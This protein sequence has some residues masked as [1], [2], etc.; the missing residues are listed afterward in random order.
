MTW[1]KDPKKVVVVALFCCIL[2]GS[3]FPVLKISYDLLGLKAND[4]DAKILFAG[5]RF[6]I[7]GIALFIVSK[8]G[9]KLDMKLNKQEAKKLVLLGFV[10]TSLLYYFF[11]NALANTTGMKAAIL[12]SISTFLVVIISHFIYKDDRLNKQK[13]IGLSL[14]FLGIIL[15]NVE[16]GFGGFHFTLLGEGFM[17]FA[18]IAGTIG[19]FLAKEASQTIHPFK[20]TS[21][22][23][24]LGS[25][26]LLAIGNVRSDMSALPFNRY[27]LG[28]LFYASFISATA[29]G[30][31]FMLLKYNKAG[32]ITLYRFMIPISGAVL[33]SI[34]ISGESFTINLILGMVSVAIGLWVINKKQA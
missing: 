3:A 24:I 33:S 25:S 20:V 26:L 16:S 18:G 5:I 28:L 29:F 6:M 17:I 12:Q 19:T 34:L 31:W 10:N 23:L 2:W 30:L 13:V 4:F 8:Y 1:F 15:I 32:E 21:W 11:Y 7:A 14:G 22:Q 9:L 27:S